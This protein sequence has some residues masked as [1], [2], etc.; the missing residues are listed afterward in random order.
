MSV[1]PIQN[2]I[3]PDRVT[4]KRAQAVPVAQA[5]SLGSGKR[6]PGLG[7]EAVERDCGRFDEFDQPW[8]WTRFPVAARPYVIV[9]AAALAVGTPLSAGA[10]E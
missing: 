10:V 1:F 5:R 6:P 8:R 3:D 7:H 4:E 2:R 9:S